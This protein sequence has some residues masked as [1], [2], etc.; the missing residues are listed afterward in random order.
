MESGRCTSRSADIRTP[1]AGMILRWTILCGLTVRALMVCDR[2]P[3]PP[4]SPPIVMVTVNY[5]VTRS[6]SERQT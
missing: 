6:S 1:V 5:T 3:L 4:D 2:G